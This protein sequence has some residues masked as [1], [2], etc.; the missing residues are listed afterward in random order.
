MART[1]ASARH[2]ELIDIRNDLRE[3]NLHDTEEPPL[4]RQEIPADLNS[5]LRTGRSIDGTFNDLH[6]PDDG[7]GRPKVW[8]KLRAAT[9][10]SRHG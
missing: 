5:V 7:C 1:S 2:G 9:C 3:Q 8:P 4:K 6:V 10:F